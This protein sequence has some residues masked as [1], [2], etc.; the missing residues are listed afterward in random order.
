MADAKS[1]TKAAESKETTTKAETFDK[2]AE[3]ATPTETSA[4]YIGTSPERERT[5]MDDKGLSQANPAILTG[6]PVPDPRH[7][8]DDADALKG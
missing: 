7:G 1:T 2:A 3:A 6:G 8:V 4:S 5:G